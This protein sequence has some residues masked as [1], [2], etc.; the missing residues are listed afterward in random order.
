MAERTLFFW[1]TA[2][3]R[4]EGGPALH[5]QDESVWA[6]IILFSLLPQHFR[7]PQRGCVRI[8]MIHTYMHACIHATETSVCTCKHACIH[9]YPHAFTHA[10]VRA[11]M[12]TYA[13]A[14]VPTHKLTCMSLY[15]SHV[16]VSHLHQSLPA[17]PLATTT[18]SSSDPSS[19]PAACCW[20]ASRNHRPFETSL[21]P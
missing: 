1:N 12:S 21:F 11:C 19:S 17:G 15:I 13:H 18:C 20:E 10:Y 16:G 6:C 7:H 8:R 4:H 9:A 2:A 14:Y 5:F 3:W